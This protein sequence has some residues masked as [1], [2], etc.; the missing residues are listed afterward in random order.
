MSELM[1]HT[2]EH[3]LTNYVSSCTF[4]PL[5]FPMLMSLVC[6]YVKDSINSSREGI[7]QVAPEANLN[8]WNVDTNIENS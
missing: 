5:I 3:P 4:G 6:F 1:H 7:F 8:E 2:S